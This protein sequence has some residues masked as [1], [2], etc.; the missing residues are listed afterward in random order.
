[1]HNSTVQQPLTTMYTN[2]NLTIV[3]LQAEVGSSVNTMYFHSII[4]ECRSTHHWWSKR[5]WFQVKGKRSNGRFTDSP[6]Y[7]KRRRMIRADTE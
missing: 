3:M 6:H 4:H 5:L 7:C 1:M 2:S